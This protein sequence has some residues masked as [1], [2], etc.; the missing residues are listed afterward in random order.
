MI[1]FV[2]AV[3]RSPRSFRSSVFLVPLGTEWEEEN[4]VG[5][6]L[7]LNHHR[8][9]GMIR[10]PPAGTLIILSPDDMCRRPIRTAHP[11]NISTGIVSGRVSSASASYIAHMTSCVGPKVNLGLLCWSELT[12]GA[13]VLVNM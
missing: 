11:D 7:L 10:F 6:Y 13:A 2:C 8:L 5:R 12:C 1:L 4:T 3:S 9:N